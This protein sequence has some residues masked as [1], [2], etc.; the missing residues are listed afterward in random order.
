MRR[1]LLVAFVLL[2]AG[3]GVFAYTYTFS[4]S[5]PSPSHASVLAPDA[6]LVSGAD[7]DALS[8]PSPALGMGSGTSDILDSRMAATLRAAHIGVLRFGDIGADDYDWQGGCIYGDIGSRPEC[9]GVAGQGGKLDRFLTFAGEVGAQPLI[10]VNGE[11]DDP[12]QAAGL[13]AYYWQHCAHADGQPCPDPYW[14]IG[15]SPA[16]WKHFAVPLSRRQPS[17]A[18]VIQPDQYAAL[19]ISYAAAMTQATPAAVTRATKDYKLKIVA[20]EWITGATDQSWVDSVIAVDTHYA[21]LLYAP[22]GPPPSEQDVVGAVEHGYGGRLGVDQWLQDLRDSLAQFSQSGSISMII[23][24]WSIDTNISAVE[25]DVY[26]GYA[27][28]LFTAQMIAHVW[29]DAQNGGRNP[30]LLAVQSPIT[31]QAQEPFDITSL[32]PRPAVSVYTLIGRYFAAHP[33]SIR[34]GDGARTGGIVAAA[35]MAALNDTRV[36]LINTDRGKARTVD[37]QGMPSGSYEMWWIMPDKS[38]ATGVS[39]IQ[40]RSVSSTRVTVPPGAIAVVRAS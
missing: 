21:P 2:V 17:D 37:L 7:S 23:G 28:A 10:V 33:I 1:W 34:E 40:H 25:P 3:A 30:L 19:V 20:D 26:G 16:S 15:D 35:A 29:Q 31:G 11:V 39:A 22:P 13:V 18:Q 14:E 38:A 12:Q 27:Q 6:V 4:T 9:Y 36:L 5:S 32:Q 8:S 24:R